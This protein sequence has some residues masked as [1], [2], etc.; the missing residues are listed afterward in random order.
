MF[1]LQQPRTYYL[2]AFASVIMFFALTIP[3]FIGFEDA[4]LYQAFIN[5]PA[6]QGSS[7]AQIYHP[8]VH[9]MTF[10]ELVEQPGIKAIA[11]N[12]RSQIKEMRKHMET[13]KANQDQQEFLHDLVE[14]MVR[15]ELGG[16][17]EE[18]K[19]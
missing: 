18:K 14:M 1:S 11:Q 17:P 19:A 7:K 2:L 5:Q 9:N 4:W 13:V 8:H 10:E 16:G 12:I 6:G 15:Q 3:K